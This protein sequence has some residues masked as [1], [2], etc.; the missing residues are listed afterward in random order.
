MR[1]A[2]VLSVL[3]LSF[4]LL[5]LAASGAD[6]EGQ[7][8][9]GIDNLAI[10]GHSGVNPAHVMDVEISGDRAY[11]L[12]G[13]TSGLETY[14]ISDPANPTRIQMQDLASWGAKAYGNHLFTFKRKNGFQ[15]YDISGSTPVSL[16]GH[17]PAGDDIL[18]ENGVL[19]G[20]VLHV[21]AL[22]IGIDS[23]DVSS[24]GS[25]LFLNHIALAD[26]ACWD[27]EVSGTFL[28]V[29][30]GRFG[31]SVV[32]LT[33]QT[34][35]AVLPLPGL[36]N[37]IVLN[38]NVAVLS[39]GGDGIATV[40]ISSPAAP[41]LLDTASTSGSAFGSGILNGKLAVG[42]WT[43][44]EVFDVSDPSNIV[45]TAWDNTKTWAM[46]A[47]IEPYGS[48]GLV[49]VADWRGM[50]TYLTAPDAGPDIDVSP[51]RLDF[52]EVSAQENLFVE[53]SN[54]GSQTL[55]V[56]VGSIPAGFEV[57]PDL[58]SVPPGGSQLV[59]VSGSGTG[60][61]KESIEYSSNDPDEPVAKQY[62]YKNNTA[63][64][65]V[66]SEAPDFTLQDIDDYWHYLSDYRGSVVF[67]EFGGLW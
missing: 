12:I 56:T 57:S 33:T 10:L 38:G 58:F 26:N 25:P 23:F 32:D 66:D 50:T 1:P 40:D 59:L 17:D 67:M 20:S 5:T 48:D 37:H 19:D 8:K 35:V 22:H 34:E 4:S 13:F 54:T 46:G 45:K 53:V 27:V 44:V 15:I 3:L 65:Q 61:V 2:I 41:Q 42:S 51:D 39:L 14:D 11:M 63:F 36:A 62:V 7:Q 28:F 31:M 60:Q 21:A 30:N 24:P 18:Y 55:D 49:V 29:A 64:P 6:G 43:A 16:G 9:A 47:D 52:G